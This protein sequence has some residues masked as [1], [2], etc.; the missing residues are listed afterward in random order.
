MRLF[1]II[2]IIID[3]ISSP[4]LSLNIQHGLII[5]FSGQQITKK[6]ASRPEADAVE[7]PQRFVQDQETT[8]STVVAAAAATTTSSSSGTSSA[9]AAAG[10][11]LHCLA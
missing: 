2:I 10:H 3:N 9:P 1:F 5:R 6:R 11:N 8:S 4:S 7:S